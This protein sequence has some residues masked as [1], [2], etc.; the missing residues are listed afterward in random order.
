MAE[1]VAF[2]EAVP[3]HHQLYVQL[4]QE[5]ADGLWVERSFPSEQDTASRFGVSVI[6]S[7]AALDR[8]A[9]EGWL[10]RQRGRGTTVIREPKPVLPGTGPAL[11]PLADQPHFRYRVLSAG[12]QVAP[13]AACAAF[14]LPAGQDLW[15]CSRLRLHEDRPHSVTHNAQLPELGLRHSRRDLSRR[16]MVPI[17]NDLGIKLSRMRRRIS[18]THAPPLV[19]SHLNLTIVD[20]VLVTEFT[21]HDDDDRTVEWVRIYVHPDQP[22]ADEIMD[23]GTRVWAPAVLP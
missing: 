4:R 10:A 7:R 5:I 23:L 12:V 6:T 8:L 17:L 9:R 14:G 21:L 18:V 22:A 15:Q 1:D 13:A 2:D 3:L 11:V 16:P 20:P 19:A